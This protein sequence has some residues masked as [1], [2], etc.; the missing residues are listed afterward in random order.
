MGEVILVAS[1]KGGTGKTTATANIG[2]ALSG[3]GKLTVL[4]DMDMGL[5]NLDVALG[6]ESDIVYDVLDIID[7]SCT[8]DDALIRD[9][10]YENLYFIPAPQTRT[11]TAYNEDKFKALWDTLRNRFD[12]CVIDA[13]AGVDGGFSYAMLGADRGIIVTVPE[14]A[15]LRDADR[16]ISIFEDEGISDVRLIINRVRVDMIN[17]GIMMNID[18]CMDILSIPIIGIVPDDTEL[19]VSGLKGEIA[20]SNPKSAA[21]MAFLNIAKRIEGQSVPV[22]DFYIK[23]GIFRRFKNLFKK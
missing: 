17:Q 1:G 15:A 7:G 16:V 21:G 19:L 5:R 6:L 14:T 3:S 18:D 22:M 8:L 20:V 12:Y 13:P 4:V 10:R 9:S 2:A 23:K 11:L